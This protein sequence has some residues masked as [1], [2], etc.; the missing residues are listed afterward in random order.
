[1]YENK[2]QLE[3]VDKDHILLKL[4]LPSFFNYIL[5]VCLELRICL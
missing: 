1:M 4:K 3:S 2:K 5:I